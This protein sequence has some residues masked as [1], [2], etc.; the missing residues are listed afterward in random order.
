MRQGRNTVK[1]VELGHLTSHTQLIQIANMPEEED[2][3][4]PYEFLKGLSHLLGE[5]GDIKSPQEVLKVVTEMKAT[6][7]LVGRCCYLNILRA[8]KS[9]ETLSKFVEIGG[10]GIMNSW[11]TDAKDT[12]NVPLL[13][14]VLKVLK[15]MPVTIEQLKKNNTAKVVKQLSKTSDN[16]KT[17]SMASSLV[18]YWMDM[19]HAK[20][21]GGAEK[22]NKKHHHHKRHHEDTKDSKT[23]AEKTATEPEK[24][25]KARSTKVKTPAF[26]KM[27]STGLEEETK[28]PAPVKKSGSIDK[29]PG[30]S[31]PAAKRPSS[32]IDKLLTPPEKKHR[33]QPLN[34]TTNSPV[35]AKVKIIPAKP[36]VAM[37]DTG[38][39][40]ALSA[41]TAKSHVIKVKKKPKN[42]KP[43]TP[44]S[45]T[46]PKG[47]P[48]GGDD[49][50]RTPSPVDGELKDERP[51]TPIEEAMDSDF[52]KPTKAEE[53]ERKAE[54]D[55]EPPEPY[56]GGSI[57]VSARR[58]NRRKKSVKWAVDDAIKEVFYFEMDESERANVNVQNFQEA[59][60]REMLLERQ[61]METAK[62][63]SA[64][65]MIEK[66]GWKPPPRI[67][68]PPSTVDYGYQ[69][70]QR[71]IQKEREQCVLQELF[72]SK[73]SLPDSPH[74]PDPEPYTREEPKIIPLDEE[75]VP[76]VDFFE[77]PPFQPTA[78]EEEM[79]QRPPPQQ[80]QQQQQHQMLPDQGGM[81]PLAGVNLPPA[82]ANLMQSMQKKQTP[83]SQSQPQP[84]T[85]QANPGFNLLSSLMG[86][87][88][89]PADQSPNQDPELLTTQLKDILN[90]VQGGPGGMGPPGGPQGPG[91]H[92]MPM[93]GQPGPM[94]N[95]M[96]RGGPFDH[97]G[98]M[99]PG[100]P[101]MGP[102][103]F[104]GNQ[105]G[106]PPFGPDGGPPP[107]QG[108]PPNRGPPPMMHPPGPG[109]QWPGPRGP[110]RGPMRGR[111]F[112]GRGRGRGRGDRSHMPVCRHFMSQTG[113]RFEGSCTFYHPGVNGPPLPPH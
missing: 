81:N 51:G 66:K 49:K 85:S 32:P 87:E 10:W 60:H 63:L 72:F 110:P 13:H 79:L 80:H 61:A 65:E 50:P 71:D 69:S 14:E 91:M 42:A 28:L 106:P 2:K 73:S 8:T 41:N 70:L 6:K 94:G 46:A 104:P 18:T 77:P 26:A 88:H 108:G 98:P 59:A 22:P 101:Q 103:P 34:R 43:G 40:E 84:Q 35:Q 24:P 5:E 93:D 112:Q 113:C 100:G 29:R 11:L 25:K 52:H 105:N 97:Q 12:N 7:K 39:M 58:K 76:E 44:T 89:P 82:L 3:M 83:T 111:P 54:E 78:E 16:E 107:F 48:L 37:D 62:R 96:P 75:M 20:G 86:G 47:N 17:K 1:T 30:S 4:N 64:D 19:I 74:E 53:A 38:F 90:K 109:P 102:G 9:P 15:H 92:Q 33:P 55:L 36:F 56:K 68:I 27:R 21:K 57:L 95:G 31:I 99:G 23:S 45:P 67:D